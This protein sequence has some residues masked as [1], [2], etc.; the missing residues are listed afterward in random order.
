MSFSVSDVNV[1]ISSFLTRE[2]TSSFLK[3]SKNLRKDLC[4][5]LYHNFIFSENAGIDTI[6]SMMK[7]LDIIEILELRNCSFTEYLLL[8]MKKLKKLI[9]TKCNV[10]VTDYELQKR[11][12]SLK[13]LVINN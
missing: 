6:K 4:N 12:K 9:L 8:P 5:T 7:H 2:D 1:Y 10:V 11:Y 3:T 13:R